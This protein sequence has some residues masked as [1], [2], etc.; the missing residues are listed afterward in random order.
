MPRILVVE[1]E[2]NIRR[3]LADLLVKDGHQVYEADT[4]TRATDLVSARQLDLILTDQKLPDG[5]GLSILSEVRKIDYS[6]PVVV[7][8]AHA[9]VELAVE[10][11]RLGAF[12][13]IAKP[14]TTK[15]VQAIVARACERTT[16]ARENEQLKETIKRM[17]SQWK[18]IGRS[19]AMQ[20]VRDQIAQVAHTNAT[21][22]IMGET[23]TGKELVA[24]AIHQQSPRFDK[25]F[26][27][28]NCA[29]L[30]ESLLE[31]EL[32]GHVRGAFT[33]ANQTRKGVFEAADGGTL[34]LDEAGEMSLGLQ[35]KLL[36]V[37]TDHKVVRVGATTPRSVDVRILVATLRDLEQRMK[38]GLFRDDLYYRLVVIPLVVPPLRYRPEDIP[39]LVDFFLNQ[40]A[41]ELKIRP[42]SISQDAIAKLQRYEFPG[43]VREL[44]NLIERACILAKSTTI[45]PADILIDSD[46][47]QFSNGIDLFSDQVLK[48]WNEFREDNIPLR[49]MM[50]RFER[51]LIFQT[52]ETTGGVQAEAARK[53]G[54]SRS[55]MTY[56]IKKYSINNR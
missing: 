44:R 55:D 10:A 39:E 15:Q 43:N 42:H 30:T 56:K 49:Q 29:A 48:I 25:P 46:H 16:F 33:G 19:P 34:F 36:R 4:L 26:I 40:V 17:E 22:L 7:L 38:E 32:F 31:S 54:I 52:L 3:F 5:E 9:S 24:R 37:L 18:L 1:D 27:A 8:T 20:K 50:D 51:A 45:Q 11:M 53:L 47:Q 41:Q 23:G 14:F 13:F 2:A 35:S 28:V 12:D 6:I 21:V